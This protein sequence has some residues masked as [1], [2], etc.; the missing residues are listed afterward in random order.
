MLN[1]TINSSKKKEKKDKACLQD[2]SKYR[3][4]DNR[5]VEAQELK[6]KNGSSQIQRVIMNKKSNRK[7][8]RRNRKF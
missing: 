7:L 3:E 4:K 5:Q 6:R 8:M 2:L 1:L